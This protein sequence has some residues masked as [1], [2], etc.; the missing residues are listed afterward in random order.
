MPIL[1]NAALTALATLWLV[2][3]WGGA[4]RAETLP[5]SGIYA[6]RADIPGGIETV[7]VEAF[8]GDAGPELLIALIGELERATIDAVPYFVIVSAS[9]GGATDAILRG[10]VRTEISDIAASDRIE[11]ECVRRDERR[12]CVEREEVRIECRQLRVSLSPRVAL[13]TLTGEMLYSH[14]N[15]WSDAA[16]YCAD[17]SILP[18]A[19]AMVDGLISSMARSIRL[20]L[21]PLQKSEDIRV[22]ESRRD[23]ARADRSA[24]RDAVRL[25]K[26][27]PLGACL[28]FQELEQRNP[29]SV[30]VI[31]NNGLCAEHE[32]SQDQAAEYY[33]RAL[34][35]DPG[36]DYPAAG[37]GRV[38]SAMRAEAAL[39]ARGWR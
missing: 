32:Q 31:F 1:R 3:G 2:G 4:A 26:N 36:K 39:A 28:R 25:T 18:S 12:K 16:T 33:R 6:A 5:I 34:A 20:D 22:M 35:I 37:L 29:Q 9:N 24:F 38:N 11:R 27:D 13:F 19:N 17:S 21:A 23:V 30:S 14:G 15:R 7:E 8:G 10:S